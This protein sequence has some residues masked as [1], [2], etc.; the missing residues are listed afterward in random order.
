MLRL[1]TAYDIF[2]EHLM[3]NEVIKFS[4]ADVGKSLAED[5]D[6]FSY[7]PYMLQHQQVSYYQLLLSLF[8]SYIY[9]F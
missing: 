8:H 5:G 4:L 7:A 9:T 6:G 1:L 2:E 3:S